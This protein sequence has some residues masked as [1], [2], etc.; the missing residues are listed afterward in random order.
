MT[1]N[2]TIDTATSSSTTQVACESYDWQGTTYTASGVYHDTISNAIGCDSLMTLNL[3]IDTATSSSTT[4]VACESYDWQGTTYTTSGVYHDTISNATGCDSLMTLNLTI[5]VIDTSVSIIGNSLEA[6][7]DSAI[8]K[9]I[10]CNTLA[11]E[12]S[13]KIFYPG[14]LDPYYV[15]ITYDG[16]TDTSGCHVIDSNTTELEYNGNDLEIMVYPNPFFDNI[17]IELEEISKDAKIIVRD[18]YGKLVYLEENINSKI[19][20]IPLK[21][22]ERGIY[23]IS[24]SVKNVNKTVRIIKL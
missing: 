16:C 10:N 1:L 11:V 24:I 5:K 15:I 2:L 3:T 17:N 21:D 22:V 23:Y 6:N 18:N 19:V 8:Y 20:T 7:Q 13:S 12:D 4:Q 14:N 9:W